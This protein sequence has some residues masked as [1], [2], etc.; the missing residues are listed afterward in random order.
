MAVAEHGRQGRILDPLGEQE[1]ALGLFLRE[2]SALEAELFQRG[3]DFACDI[4]R[5]I[6]L[7]LRIL[8]FCRDRDAARKIGLEGSGIEIGLGAGD[9]GG[10]GHW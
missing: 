7:S 5:K 3:C 1:R 4:A 8:A 9:G 6:R 2:G 10:S